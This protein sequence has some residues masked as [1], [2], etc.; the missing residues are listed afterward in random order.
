MDP[1]PA[2]Y[3]LP[4]PNAV[5]PRTA[6]A[7][8]A[9]ANGAPPRDRRPNFPLRCL[10]CRDELRRGCDIRFLQRIVQLSELSDQPGQRRRAAR[11]SATA[12]T[13]AS[14]AFNSGGGA[15]DR[16]DHRSVTG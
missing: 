10:H 12:T 4:L 2:V 13:A 6:P 14:S 8:S 9:V 11:R 3:E 16:V 7:G 1:Q 15:I 5:S